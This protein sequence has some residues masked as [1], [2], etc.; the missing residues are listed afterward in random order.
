MGK[1]YYNELG[2]AK[3]ADAGALKK[4]YRKLAVKWV[5]AFA[6]ALLGLLAALP[7][8]SI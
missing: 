3:D 6:V 5:S 1:D 4:A 7:L 8:A 2:V